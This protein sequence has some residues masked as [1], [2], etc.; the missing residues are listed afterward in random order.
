MS[1]VEVCIADAF[2]T[3][4]ADKKSVGALA[5]KTVA[6]ASETKVENAVAEALRNESKGV[7]GAH[8]FNE[9]VGF[10]F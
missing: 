3:L 7:H 1:D 2:A 10:V 8:S 5:D 6:S 9:L 4:L